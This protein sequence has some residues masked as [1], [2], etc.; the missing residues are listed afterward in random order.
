MENNF[1]MDEMNWCFT[2]QQVSKLIP[3]SR[4]AVYLKKKTQNKTKEFTLPHLTVSCTDGTALTARSRQCNSLG[5]TSPVV[6]VH[7]GN[8]ALA[9]VKRHR[10]MFPKRLL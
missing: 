9:F 1:G 3:F 8:Q 7:L 6:P 4:R 2:N 5:L 10:T